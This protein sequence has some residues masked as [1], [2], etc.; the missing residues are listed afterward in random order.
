[1]LKCLRSPQ[2]SSLTL[3]HHLDIFP[4]LLQLIASMGKQYIVWQEIFDN[5]LTVSVATQRYSHYPLLQSLTFPSFTLSP[6]PP[7]LTLSPSILS[8]SL[9]SSLPSSRLLSLLPLHPTP[10]LP[11]QFFPSSSPQ[12]LPNTVIDVWKGGSDFASE[13]YNVTK[14]GLK[15]ILSACWYLDLISYGQ[16]WIH[17]SQNILVVILVLKCVNV[18]VLSLFAVLQL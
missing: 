2:R 13:M 18:G 16:D 10:L 4:S 11:L 6:P 3:L 7:P 8:P 5:G 15:T 9:L 14:A 17:V 1:M 12:V